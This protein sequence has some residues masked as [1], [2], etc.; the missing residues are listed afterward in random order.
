MKKIR[1]TPQTQD[2]HPQSSFLLKFGFNLLK[3][4]S[5][6]IYFKLLYFQTCFGHYIQEQSNHLLIHK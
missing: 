2:C 4:L 1:A 5:F 3:Q 6:E